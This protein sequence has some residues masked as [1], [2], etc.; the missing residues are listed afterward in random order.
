MEGLD[1][2]GAG[3]HLKELWNDWNLFDG[4]P[5]PGKIANAAGGVVSERSYAQY[6]MR[7][8]GP[9]CPRKGRVLSSN[10]VGIN[11]GIALPEENHMTVEIREK[12]KLAL[13]GGLK[14]VAAFRARAA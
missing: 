1:L 10:S 11:S 13:Q 9:A 5:A 14:A 6:Q 2:G 12:Q 8:V 4:T 3:L 7:C